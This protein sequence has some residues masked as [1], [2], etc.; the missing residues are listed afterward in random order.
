M[1]AAGGL[2]RT[3]QRVAVGKFGTSEALLQLAQLPRGHIV[4][5]LQN[6][7]QHFR[8]HDLEGG[9]A[10]GATYIVDLDRLKVQRQPLSSTPL[11]VC[12]EL[13]TSF[14]PLLGVQNGL[15]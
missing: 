11:R 14:P 12:L 7:P 6:P 15:F 10:A 5:F 3:A 13:R 1:S 2:R 4:F 8:Q 9:R